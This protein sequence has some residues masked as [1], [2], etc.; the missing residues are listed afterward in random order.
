MIATTPG[1][2][3]SHVS[4]S[5][6]SSNPVGALCGRPDR[7]TRLPNAHGSRCRAGAVWEAAA[8]QCGVAHRRRAKAVPGTCPASVC[9]R[10]GS[11]SWLGRLGHPTPGRTKDRCVGRRRADPTPAVCCALRTALTL[12][13]PARPDRRAAWCVLDS[14]EVERPPAAA[15]HAAQMGL[16]PRMPC[17]DRDPGTA[18]IGVDARARADLSAGAHTGAPSAGPAGTRPRSGPV[19]THR[20][21]GRGPPPA[22]ACSRED[23]R[24][25]NPFDNQTARIYGASV[26]AVT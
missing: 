25:H 8:A 1:H 26:C 7:G 21:A 24:R 11:A 17:L 20:R 13:H 19:S 2:L 12:L 14:S 23:H 3:A 18:L 15:S 4:T 22:R 16:R 10:P 9:T 5:S 6:K